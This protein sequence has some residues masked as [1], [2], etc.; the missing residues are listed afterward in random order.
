MSRYCENCRYLVCEGYE[1]PEYY[2]GVGVSEDDD[3]FFDDNKGC[4]CTYNIRTLEKRKREA[5]HD[6]Y[7]Y[8]LGYIDYGLMPS[9]DYTEENEKI[10]EHYRDLIRHTL[11]M[12]N[13][14]SY[15]RHG[16]KFYRPYRNYFEDIEGSIDYPYW[17]KMVEAGMA[18]KKEGKKDSYGD[19]SV[20]YSVT[21][22]GM[23]WVGLHDC[24]Y[25][26]DMK[27]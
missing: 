15:I 6:E 7:L 17:E 19:K 25:I 4:G 16:K 5:E 9:M 12:D 10:L 24:V 22:V 21:R 2:C 11:G 20:W 8:Y 18:E 26:Y 1:Y 13:R 27:K 14:A 23:D 3:K